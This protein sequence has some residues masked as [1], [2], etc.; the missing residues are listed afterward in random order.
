[1]FVTCWRGGRRRSRE[2]VRDDI[3][4]VGREQVMEGLGHSVL[5]C[6]FF[7]ERRRQ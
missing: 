6:D 4:E 7:P 3:G 5:E 1:M 2:G